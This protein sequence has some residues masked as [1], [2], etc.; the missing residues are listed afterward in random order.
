MT[1]LLCTVQ[2]P[3]L[4]KCLVMGLRRNR[5]RAKLNFVYSIANHSKMSEDSS[6]RT[7]KRPSTK[8]KIE[9]NAAEAFYSPM[10]IPPSPMMKK[11]G[12]GTGVVV[13]R[14]D[15]ETFSPW[16][17]KSPWAVKK[18]KK[19]KKEAFKRLKLESEIL[20]QLDHPNI[21]SYRYNDIIK[22]IIGRNITGIFNELKDV[23]SQGKISIYTNLL[24]SNGVI[25]SSIRL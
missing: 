12:C 18:A 20:K 2:I 13:Y 1:I 15:R 10:I 7:P 3:A 6:F 4:G 25:S 24:Q 9:V 23:S 21:I 17:K 11:L 8:G 22:T 16:K 14:L 19:V 5:Q